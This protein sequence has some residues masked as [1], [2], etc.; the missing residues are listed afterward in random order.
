MVKKTLSIIIATFLINLL[1]GAAEPQGRH[2]ATLPT[3]VPATQTLTWNTF[4]GGFGI[5]EDGTALALDD[6]GNV[7]LR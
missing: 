3:M 4:L 7:H 2:E 1:G 6:G 5:D